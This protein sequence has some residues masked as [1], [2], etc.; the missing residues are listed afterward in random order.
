MRPIPSSEVRLCLKLSIDGL[1]AYGNKE[2]IIALRDQMNWLLES[3]PSEHFECHVMLTMEN[4]ESKFGGL[5]PANVW[6]IV[7]KDLIGIDDDLINEVP[8]NFELTIMQVRDFD[9]DELEKHK[10]QPIID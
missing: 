3:D 7:S 10:I 6:T 5:V 2:A 1:T 9:L 8:K 4:D